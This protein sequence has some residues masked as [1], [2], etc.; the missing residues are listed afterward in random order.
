MERQDE[1]PVLSVRVVETAPPRDAASATRVFLR[2]VA[3]P[4]SL[5]FLGVFV[6]TMV[7]TAVQ[8]SWVP[9]SQTHTLAEAI[10][11]LTVPVE[12]VS[13]VFGFLGRDLVA[14]TGMGV[15]AGIWGMIGLNLVLSRPGST[16]SGLAF[17]LVI[18]AV[19]LCM[20][21]VGGVRGKALAGGVLLTTAARWGATA[22]YEFSGSSVAEAVAGAVGI[23]LAGAALYA[24]LAFELEDQQRRTVL[25]TLRRGKGTAAMERDLAGQVAQVANE[26]GVRRQL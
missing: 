10:L 25:P 18:G 20:P 8:L 3:N 6:G 23:V 22:A 24:S 9:V 13:C 5:G 15:Q 14:A 4:L 1:P 16:S 7:L 11:V 21:A 19:A 26:A 12:L 2:P 17:I